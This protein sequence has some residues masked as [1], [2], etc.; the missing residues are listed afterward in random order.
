MKD[1][2]FFISVVVISVTAIFIWIMLFGPMKG[3]ERS[4]IQDSTS[5]AIAA[6]LLLFIAFLAIVYT[7]LV[8]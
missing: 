8:L 7:V 4:Y 5:F 3:D 2:L 1:I 6:M